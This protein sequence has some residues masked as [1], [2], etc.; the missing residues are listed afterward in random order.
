[1]EWKHPSCARHRGSVLAELI[2][3]ELKRKVG[4]GNVLYIVYSVVFFI[5]PD[6]TIQQSHELIAS[7]LYTDVLYTEV[8]LIVE[9]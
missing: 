8:V 5:I 7:V 3:V 9:H 4:G 1:M 6:N 2:A